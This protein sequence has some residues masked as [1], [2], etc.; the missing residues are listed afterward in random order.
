MGFKVE[1]QLNP[2]ELM[3]ICIELALKAREKGN[4][5]YGALL[6]LD[7]RILLTAENS[8]NTDH[9][10]TCHAELNLVS[11]ATRQLDPGTLAKTTLFTSTE[12]CAMCAAAMFW[13][14]I[15]SVVYGCAAETLGEMTG[16]SFVIPCRHIFSFGN[17]EVN[18]A[19]PIL[20]EESAAV[21]DGFW[22]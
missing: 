4:H 7:G 13:A 9:D 20:P 17:R 6:A 10:I 3:R 18:V 8:V 1:D 2:E 16:G 11:L 19:G 14:G 22:S 21:H 15:P 12:P 5:P